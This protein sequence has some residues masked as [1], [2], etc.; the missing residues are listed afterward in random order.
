MV[1]D[2][3]RFLEFIFR[4]VVDQHVGALFVDHVIDLD[5]RG[6]AQVLRIA[7][8]AQGGHGGFIEPAELL[9]QLGDHALRRIGDFVHLHR[10]GQH[11]GRLVLQHLHDV[12]D[13]FGRVLGVLRQFAHLVRHHGKPAPGLARARRLDRRIQRQQIGLVGDGGDQP[14]RFADLGAAR[15][16]LGDRLVGVID[17][18]HD[19]VQ[20]LHHIAHR[21]AAF[22]R[23][24]ARAARHI[25]QPLHVVGD[26]L[27]VVLAG[28]QILQQVV[29]VQT[30]RARQQLGA[31]GP[32]FLL[33]HSFQ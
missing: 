27:Q 25:R 17:P 6:E 32:H 5:Q 33:L 31:H 22:L 13:R 23:I 20:P 24:F 3:D 11:L 19:A 16:E 1:I 2:A 7:R 21:A 29:G 9:L 10:I 4:V 28:D 15:V 30:M 12:P 18:L 14:D 26:A 8:A